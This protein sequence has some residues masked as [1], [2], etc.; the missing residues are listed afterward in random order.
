MFALDD[1]CKHRQVPL[2]RGMVS[3]TF[4]RCLLH[5]IKFARSGRCY[6]PNMLLEE[7][8]LRAEGGMQEKGR[9]DMPVIRKCRGCRRS[10]H[11]L[12]DASRWYKL[13]S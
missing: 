5:G 13:V 7:M 10:D 11:S 4:I 12:H 1:R 2:S 3:G 9:L 8:P 6:S